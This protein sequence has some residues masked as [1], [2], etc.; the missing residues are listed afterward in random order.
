[1]NKDYQSQDVLIDGFATPIAPD[2]QGG[3]CD[4]AAALLGEV[5]CD[6]T[7]P[8]DEELGG[9]TCTENTGQGASEDA[10]ID[11]AYAAAAG[12]AG[13]CGAPIYLCGVEDIG[14]GNYEATVK[15]CCV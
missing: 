7:C 10:A 14:G 1:V 5:P 13:A 3:T 2:A 8:T 9:G 4:L 12:G 15:Y 6:P 11:A